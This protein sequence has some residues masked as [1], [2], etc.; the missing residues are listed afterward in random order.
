MPGWGLAIKTIEVIHEPYKREPERSPSADISIEG[1]NARDRIK[2]TIISA[3][4]PTAQ[5]TA[6]PPEGWET[7]R[8]KLNSLYQRALKGEPPP[9]RPIRRLLT[10]FLRPKNGQGA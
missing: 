2:A 7:Y 10:R 6:T 3:V 5:D 8:Q 4:A 9:N 1:M